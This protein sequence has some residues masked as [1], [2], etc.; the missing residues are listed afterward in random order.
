ML[1]ANRHP[2]RW[3]HLAVLRK[4]FH[5]L[6]LHKHHVPRRAS[7]F[8]R[9]R[10]GE[11]Q[12]CNRGGMMIVILG[13]WWLR[14]LRVLLDLNE[15]VWIGEVLRGR[16]LQGVDVRTTLCVPLKSCRV[17][18]WSRQSGGRDLLSFSIWTLLDAVG[19]AQVG[20]SLLR[21]QSEIQSNVRRIEMDC[22]PHG[23]EGL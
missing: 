2:R 15:Y 8:R 22:K 20:Y 17:W 6:D 3:H 4:C 23:L 5:C 19:Q 21:F 18:I 13:V 1:H 16:G 14:N 11:Q 9:R 12:V 10:H 7:Y